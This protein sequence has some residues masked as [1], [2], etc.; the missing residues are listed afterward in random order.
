MK[1]NNID[2]DSSEMQNGNF[3]KDPDFNRDGIE[4]Y[5]TSIHCDLSEYTTLLELKKPLEN[6][7]LL[8]GRLLRMGN[9]W[10]VIKE[11]KSG[12]LVVWGNLSSIKDRNQKFE[13]IPSYR[14]K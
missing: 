1:K 13:I 2:M 9:Q 6:I 8:P 14:L 4:G 3:D 5:I 11:V 12:K 7:K 10:S